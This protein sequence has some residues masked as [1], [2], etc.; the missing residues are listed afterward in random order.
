MVE[1]INETNKL[2]ILK[3]ST[4]EPQLFVSCPERTKSYAGIVKF[5]ICKKIYKTT[6]FK[7][8]HTI[9]CTIHYKI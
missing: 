5:F 4:V 9:I 3:H 7:I 1:L 8:P 2:A 6:C